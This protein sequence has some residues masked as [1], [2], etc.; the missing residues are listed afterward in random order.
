MVLREV[1]F[2]KMGDGWGFFGEFLETMPYTRPTVDLFVELL[3]FRYRSRNKIH[4]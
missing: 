2:A 1:F 3:N 4:D